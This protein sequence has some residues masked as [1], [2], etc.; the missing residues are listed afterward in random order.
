MGFLSDENNI[1]SDKLAVI[2]LH[3]RNTTREHYW[4]D[5]LYSEKELSPWVDKLKEIKERKERVDTIFVYFN[6]HYSGKAIVN[7]LQFKEMM[8]E[9]PLSEIEKYM[10][11][12][13]SKYLDDIL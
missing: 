7:A 2:R 10:L 5:Y 3:G 13:S 6:N 9:K 1:T 12:K 4:Y 8:D 11:E